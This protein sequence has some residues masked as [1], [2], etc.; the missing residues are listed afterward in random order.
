M[1]NKFRLTKKILSA[2]LIMILV[3]S[4]SAAALAAGNTDNNGN[5]DSNGGQGGDTSEEDLPGNNDENKKNEFALAIKAEL[6]EL[7]QLRNQVRESH[8]ANI[9]LR[10]RLQERRQVL[11]QIENQNLDEEKLERIKSAVQAL[12]Q[13]AKKNKNHIDNFRGNM[14]DLRKNKDALDLPR[15]LANLDALQSKYIAMLASQDNLADC[16]SVVLAHLESV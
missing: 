14:S 12:G 4:F 7:K 16:L 2:L 1:K 8:K 3:F 11:N 6:A 13:E 9:Q 5:S 10:Q 15:A